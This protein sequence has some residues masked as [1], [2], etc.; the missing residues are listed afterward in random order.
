M[1]SLADRENKSYKKQKECHIC[2]KE[3][4]TNETNENEFKLYKKA[5]DH[6]DF[7]EKFKGAAHN[8]CNLRYKVPKEIPVVFN[9]GSTNDYHFIIKQLAEEF[10][11]EFECFGEN[12]QKYIT[13]SAPIEKEVVNGK[14][15]IVNG[16]KEVAN[17]KKEEEEVA[18]SKKEEDDDDSKKQDDNSKK[19]KQSRRN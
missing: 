8:I 1:I 2:K 10:K 19:R 9:N 6:C 13:F 15:E 18:N 14:K 3:F 17:G 7:T 12:T 11:G 16:K 5:W 4:C